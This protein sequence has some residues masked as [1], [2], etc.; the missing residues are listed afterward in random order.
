MNMEQFYALMAKLRPL[1]SLKPIS[2]AGWAA[3]HLT[4]EMF[5]FKSSKHLSSECPQNAGQYGVKMG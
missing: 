1:I 3:L 5:A 4:P 2:F